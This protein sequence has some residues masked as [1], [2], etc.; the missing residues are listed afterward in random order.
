VGKDLTATAIPSALAYVCLSCGRLAVEKAGL[1]WCA[2]GAVQL[3]LSALE[4]GAAGR[5]VAISRQAILKLKLSR[6]N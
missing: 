6:L 2:H 5:V 3:P 4:V 1:G